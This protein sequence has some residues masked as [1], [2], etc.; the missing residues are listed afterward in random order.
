[1]DKGQAAVGFGLFVLAAVIV[2]SAIAG[3]TAVVF[4]AVLSPTQLVP[5]GEGCP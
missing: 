5:A 3:R 4:A 1:M 2:W